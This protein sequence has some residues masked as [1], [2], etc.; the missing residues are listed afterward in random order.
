MNSMSD[1]PTKPSG[2]IGH[3]KSI[4]LLVN[5]MLIT[6]GFLIVSA[7]ILPRFTRIFSGFGFEL[8][9]LTR[10]VFNGLFYWPLY[11]MMIFAIVKEFLI[12]NKAITS[13]INWCLIGMIFIY[14]FVFIYAICA[15]MFKIID[16]L[17]Q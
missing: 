2:E 4:W 10:I 8:P 1:Q 7:I 5:F 13:T 15:P 6:S 12:K 16:G 11:L 3:A 14:T 17:A 9:L